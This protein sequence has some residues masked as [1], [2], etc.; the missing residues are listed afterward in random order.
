MLRCG[1]STARIGSS[2][3]AQRTVP[4]NMGRIKDVRELFYSFVCFP[5]FLYVSFLSFLTFCSFVKLQAPQTAF[6]C[7]AS[8][9]AGER[10]EADKKKLFETTVCVKR[11]KQPFKQ[12]ETCVCLSPT[13]R[14]EAGRGD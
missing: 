12:I 10:K 13:L 3:R 4:A 6:G 11:V 14:T 9:S 8:R 7:G 5:L 1:T 2:Q